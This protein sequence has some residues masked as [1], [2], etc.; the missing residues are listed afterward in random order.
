MPHSNA[1]AFKYKQAALNIYSHFQT[2]SRIYLSQPRQSFS[3]QMLVKFTVTVT[4]V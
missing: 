4:K 2:A 3:T 1:K